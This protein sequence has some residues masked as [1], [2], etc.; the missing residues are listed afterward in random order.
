MAPH[1]E[2][3][4]VKAEEMFDDIFTNF[5]EYQLDE[6]DFVP[7]NTEYS[8]YSIPSLSALKKMESCSVLVWV[9]DE[10]KEVF[11]FF[12]EK[13]EDLRW[14][15]ILF[16]RELSRLLNEKGMRPSIFD[17][18]KSEVVS[19]LDNLTDEDLINLRRIECLCIEP[20]P[21]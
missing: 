6:N 8:C 5:E 20:L 19:Y 17:T 21:Y 15:K 12:D 16:F 4:V 3:M 1:I 14:T 2:G 11:D 7:V 9:P 18:D 13:L 10:V